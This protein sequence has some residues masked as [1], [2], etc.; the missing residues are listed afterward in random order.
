MLYLKGYFSVIRIQFAFY[1]SFYIVEKFLT[2]PYD[3]RGLSRFQRLIKTERNIKGYE[4]NSCVYM[5]ALSCSKVRVIVKN[6]L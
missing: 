2:E 3:F 1:A 6:E 4:Q 5:K